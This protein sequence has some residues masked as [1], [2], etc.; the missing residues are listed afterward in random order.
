MKKTIK[1][2]AILFVDSHHGIYSYQFAVEQAIQS[3]YFDLSDVDQEDINILL[4][5]LE[6]DYYFDS[7]SNFENNV[8]IVIDN[9]KHI[10]V[11]N[12]D[13]WLIP[14]SCIDQL[15]EWYI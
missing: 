5:N 14:V 2:N 15:E 9:E 13:I 11:I 12:E 1:N 8:K 10:L 7:W 4:N 3:E 6:S